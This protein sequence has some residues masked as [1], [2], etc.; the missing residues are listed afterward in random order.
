MNLSTL[1]A[2]YPRTYH[3]VNTLYLDNGGHNDLF[4]DEGEQ[5]IMGSVTYD[6]VGAIFAGIPEQ[7]VICKYDYASI[8][9]M[10]AKPEYNNPLYDDFDIIS[11][12][13]ANVPLPCDIDTWQML[14]ILCDELVGV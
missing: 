11:G 6:A 10:L 13:N 2:N 9:S 8:E 4:T 1:K 5:I 7:T 3:V 12:G 14:I